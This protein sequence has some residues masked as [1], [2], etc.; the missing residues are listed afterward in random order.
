VDS[1]GA[2][3]TLEKLAKD[4]SLDDSGEPPIH[5]PS[6]DV[7]PPDERELDTSFPLTDM[8]I[9]SPVPEDP[10]QFVPVLHDVCNGFAKKIKDTA[11][12]DND[13]A[14]D[15]AFRPGFGQLN[16]MD[17]QVHTN[18]FKIYFVPPESATNQHFLYEYHVDSDT[19][20]TR[21]KK[22]TLMKALFLSST[23]GHGTTSPQY[24]FREQSF[25]RL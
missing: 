4:L 20:H 13:T 15:L 17:C 21:P 22:K 25:L 19:E 16:E 24:Q 12:S 2:N 9:A 11:P 3:N 6:F 1:T 8:G 14:T 23:S 7:I 5:Q 18:H 10:K